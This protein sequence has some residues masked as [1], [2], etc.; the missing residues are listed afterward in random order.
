[1]RKFFS[2]TLIALG[3]AATLPAPQAAAQDQPFIGEVTYFAG[4]FAPRGW[5]TC[6][7]QLL[8]ISS[9]SALFSI[10]GTIYGGDGRSTF[11]LPDMRGRIPVHAGTGPG[12]GTY[13]LGQKGGVQDVTLTV[14]Q[15]PAHANPLTLKG[16]DSA[17]D[18]SSPAD[19]TL[20]Q[21][22]TAAYTEEVDT[23][24]A[25]LAPNSVVVAN[26]GGSLQHENRMPFLGV[27]CIIAMQGIFPSRN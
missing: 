13:R 8:T 23:L 19:G 12:L 27:N 4:N 21:S 14:N 5:A 9:N 20:A 3:L 16:V 22:A 11:G 15:L 10:V 24:A 2:T 18:G 6:D 25:T 7:G 17:A 1:M 26:S